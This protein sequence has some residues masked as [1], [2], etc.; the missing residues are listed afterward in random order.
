MSER[1]VTR[2]RFL[3][4]AGTGCLAALC[5][6]RSLDASLGAL[7]VYFVEGQGNANEKRYPIP[8]TDSV[9]IDRSVAVIIVRLAGTVF[10][11]DQTCPHQSAA[12]R[13]VERDGR[14]RCSK[15]DSQYEQD[16]TYISGRATRNMD[17][18]PVRR[19][20][21]EVVVDLTR[22]FHADDDP[23]GWAAATIDVS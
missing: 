19:V 4:H 10:A 2:R 3:A 12:V 20:G 15:H 11:L 7:P 1:P 5:S 18:M 23:A 21:N 6:V 13:W 22:S 14:F 8:A 9:S 16:G 17:R